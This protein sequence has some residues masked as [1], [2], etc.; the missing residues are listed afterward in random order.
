MNKRDIIKKIAQDT[1]M[2]VRHVDKVYESMVKNIIEVVDNGEEVN[3]RG[4]GKFGSTTK[5]YTKVNFVE[6]F[7][8]KELTRLKFKASKAINRTLTK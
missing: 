4:F 1:D 3:L 8:P 6:N 2:P 7:K 5:L